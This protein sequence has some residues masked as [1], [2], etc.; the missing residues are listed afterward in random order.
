MHVHYPHLSLTETP[1]NPKL[2]DQHVEL[3]HL[4]VEYV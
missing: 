2:D 1:Y 4:K 3:G